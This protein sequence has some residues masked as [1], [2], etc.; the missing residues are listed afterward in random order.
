M[1]GKCLKCGSCNVVGWGIQA[2]GV[3]CFR[4]NV[5]GKT[6]NE[7]FG[8]VFHKSKFLEECVIEMLQCYLS[9]NSFSTVLMIKGMTETT[10][11]NVLSKVIDRLDFFEKSCIDY[12]GYVPKVV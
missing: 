6:F 7:R 4:C 3:K 9:G 12:D 10:V 2:N 8:T 5:C 1:I 11:R